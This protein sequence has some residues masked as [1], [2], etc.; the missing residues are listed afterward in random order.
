MLKSKKKELVDYK[1]VILS[2]SEGESTIYS[3][4]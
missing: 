3:H 2:S 1:C 4:Y